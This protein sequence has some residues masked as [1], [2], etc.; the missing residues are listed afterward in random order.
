MQ[1]CN[2]PALLLLL[3]V[4]VI[5]VVFLLYLRTNLHVL[6][7]TLKIV[8]F[9]PDITATCLNTQTFYSRGLGLKSE[10]RDHL[11][12]SSFWFSSV[13]SGSASV[14]LKVS[15]KPLS[16]TSFPVHSLMLLFHAVSLSWQYHR[17]NVKWI[18]YSIC[19]SCSSLAIC[20]GALEYNTALNAQ[21]K[22][23]WS[24]M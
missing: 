9:V 10:S 17:M 22:E 11:F 19:R 24:A 23:G 15:A 20:D 13:L 14:I 16:S 6:G 5:V 7:K 1:V 12:W 2:V 3:L 18:K 21:S 4:I 8:S